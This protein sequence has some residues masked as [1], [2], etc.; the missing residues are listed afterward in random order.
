MNMNHIDA[1]NAK[2]DSGLVNYGEIQMFNM[3][4][5]APTEAAPNDAILVDNVVIV[6]Q[7]TSVV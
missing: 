5:T 6:D 1:T 2:S 3:T 4:T 7:D